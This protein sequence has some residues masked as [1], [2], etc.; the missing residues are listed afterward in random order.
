MAVLDK[1]PRGDPVAINV[2]VSLPVK[3]LNSSVE[4]FGKLGFAFDA[5]F[6]DDTAACMIVAEDIYVMLV[7]ED[8]FKTFTAAEIHHAATSARAFMAAS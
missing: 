5:R 7:A 6:T 1:T 2:F 4:F 8:K 3:S